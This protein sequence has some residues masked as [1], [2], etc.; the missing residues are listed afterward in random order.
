MVDWTCL[1][2]SGTGSFTCPVQQAVGAAPV[3]GV[4]AQLLAV[5]CQGGTHAMTPRS[6]EGLLRRSPEAGFNAPYPGIVGPGQRGRS[7]HGKKGWTKVK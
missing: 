4:F 7:W 5:L 1:S 6:G 3:A 2:A